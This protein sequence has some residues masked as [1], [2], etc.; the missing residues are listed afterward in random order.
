MSSSSS[1]PTPTFLEKVPS[2]APPAALVLLHEDNAL[3][4]PLLLS[5]KGALFQSHMFFRNRLG[6]QGHYYETFCSFPCSMRWS[7]DGGVCPEVGSVSSTHLVLVVG[8]APWTVPWTRVVLG[9][10]HPLRSWWFPLLKPVSGWLSI[11]MFRRT[12]FP[13]CASC[14][15]LFLCCRDHVEV[16]V[17]SF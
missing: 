14:F 16:F 12:L 15:I 6:F 17:C 13:F 10:F 7:N 4:A 11:L 3:P 5:T 9:P 8:I 2:W 1:L